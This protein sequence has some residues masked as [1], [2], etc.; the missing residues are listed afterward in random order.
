ML[1]KLFVD[2][3]AWALHNPA[4]AHILFISGDMTL[5]NY[6]LLFKLKLAGYNILLGTPSKPDPR[7]T[8]HRFCHITSTLWD[9]RLLSTGK[10][11][12]T[13]SLPFLP[14]SKEAHL[15]GGVSLK[16]KLVHEAPWVQDFNE[17]PSVQGD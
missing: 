10:F 5:H 8:D 11:P 17:D 15:E 7:I 6:G 1:K 14:G 9:W 12:L 3:L 2:I 4:P 13:V 16:G